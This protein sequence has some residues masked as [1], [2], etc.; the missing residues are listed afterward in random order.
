LK[1]KIKRVEGGEYLRFLE[2]YF[3][4]FRSC[5]GEALANTLL[6]FLVEKC[7]LS[8]CFVQ[9]RAMVADKIVQRFDV[10]KVPR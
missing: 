5:K 9:C 6:K 10:V 3:V 1:L 7:I 2:F 4:Y 8:L